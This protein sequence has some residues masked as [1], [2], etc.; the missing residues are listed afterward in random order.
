MEELMNLTGIIKRILVEKENTR[1]SNWELYY[2]VCKTINPSALNSKF[3]TV[4]RSH[5]EYGL[6]A[7]ESVTRARRKIVEGYPELAGNDVVEGGR[8]SSKVL[9]KEYARGNV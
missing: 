7:F 5:S 2:E 9:F 1:N 3:G 8:W 4:I 6:P